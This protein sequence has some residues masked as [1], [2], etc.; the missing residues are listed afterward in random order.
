MS[1]ASVSLRDVRRFYSGATLRETREIL[2][3]HGVDYAPVFAGSP[4]D[5]QLESMEGLTRLR[6][7]GE[8]Y[9]V[10]AVDQDNRGGA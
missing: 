9:I 5:E 3:R 6:T 1:V 8:R 4:Q 7:P 2:R 10:Y